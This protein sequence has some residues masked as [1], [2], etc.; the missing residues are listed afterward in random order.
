MTTITPAVAQQHIDRA[1]VLNSLAT[2]HTTWGDAAWN[3]GDY[4][5]AIRHWQVAAR[6][7]LAAT[8][9]GGER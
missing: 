9:S 7:S 2:V 1:F 3:D 4:V 6:F 8:Q 5:S